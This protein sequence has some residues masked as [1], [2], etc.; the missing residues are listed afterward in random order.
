MAKRSHPSSNQG[1]R[2]RLKVAQLEID[3]IPTSSVQNDEFEIFPIQEPE[4][5]PVPQVDA[6]SEEF[7]PA[8]STESLPAGPTK[9]PPTPVPNEVPDCSPVQVP[10]PGSPL[11]V[12]N[13]PL[14]VPGSPVQVPCSPVQVPGSPVQVPDCSPILQANKE[15]LPS[16]ELSSVRQSSRIAER[17]RHIAERRWGNTSHLQ[18]RSLGSDCGDGHWSEDEENDNDHE[19]VGEKDEDDDEDGDDEDGDDEDNDES[20]VTGISAWDLLG[21]GFEREAASIGMSLAHE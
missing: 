16:G 10:A 12:P 20:D 2:K 13:S 18:D 11:Q 5:S 9:S 7:L 3:Q 6:D 1:N 19:T 17:T 21:D 15:L 14:Q 4:Y 8:G